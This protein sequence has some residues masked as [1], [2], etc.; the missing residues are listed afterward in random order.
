MQHLSPREVAE[1]TG[2]SLV[3]VYRMLKAGKL[4]GRKV[5]GVW[6]IS[7]EAADDLKRTHP[8]LGQERRTKD[9]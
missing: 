4:K 8:L 5:F 9:A 3:H 1:R 2:A 7:R 6:Q